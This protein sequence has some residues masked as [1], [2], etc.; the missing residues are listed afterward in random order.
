MEI[1]DIRIRK[2]ATEGKL[3]SY[4]T[5]AF[6]GCF[7]VHNV[8]IVEGHAGTFIAMPGRKTKSGE[9]KDVAHPITPEFRQEL[10][11]KILGTYD[12]GNVQDSSDVDF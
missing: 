5:V 3:K 6:D 7:V 1:S 12:G 9:F 2:V 10:Q 11:D 4:V 8:K